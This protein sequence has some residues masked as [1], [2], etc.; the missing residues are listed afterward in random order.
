MTTVLH[1]KSAGLRASCIVGAWL[2]VASGLVTT[3]RASALPLGFQASGGWNTESED[4]LLGAGVRFGVGPVTLIANGEWFFVDSGSTYTLN[5][6]GTLNVL[7]LGVATGYLG[8]GTGMFT[9]KP[10]GGDANTEAVFNVIAGVGFDLVPLKPFGQ[11]K[12][13]VVDGDDPVVLTVGIRF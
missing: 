7:P 9:V 12:W 10:D 13:I 6:D 8:V 11:V 5:L 4:F 2:A 1:S 3:A